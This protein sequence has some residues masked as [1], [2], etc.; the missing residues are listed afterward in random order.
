MKTLNLDEN[1]L[2]Y[3]Q[4]ALEYEI[5]RETD[6]RIKQ[7]LLDLYKKIFGRDYYI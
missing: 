7:A 5:D 3:L 2:W 6:T 1:D 4:I